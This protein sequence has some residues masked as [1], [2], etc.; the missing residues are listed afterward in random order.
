M[1][2]SG[3]KI[4]APLGDGGMATVYKGLQISLQRPVAIKVLKSKLIDHREIRRRFDRESIIIARLNH[5]NIIHV[6][7]QGVTDC[8]SPY[9]VMEYAKSIGLDAAMRKGSM[10]T[11]RALD[12]FMQIAKALAYAHKNGV[13][14]CDIKPENVLID[15]EGFVRVLD[16]GIAQIYEDAKGGGKDGEGFIMG[17]ANYMA[18]EQQKGLTN[19]TEKSDIYALGVIM[20]LFFTRQLPKGNYPSPRQFDSN[21]PPELDQLIRDCLANNPDDRPASADAIKNCLLRVLQG[22]HL[23]FHQK[24]RAKVDVKK[25]FKLLDVVKE[26]DHG[27]VYLF[28]EQGT[29]TLFVLKKKPIDSPGYDVAEKLAHLEHANIVSIMGTSHNEH[30]FLLVMEYCNGGSLAERLVKPYDLENFYCVAQQVISALLAANECGIIHGNLRPTNILF[31][32]NNCVKVSDFGLDEHY[33]DSDINWYAVPGE[34]KCERADIFSLGV[35]FYQ[36]LAGETPRWKGDRLVK[37]KGFAGLP[38]PLQRMIRKMLA[39]SKENRLETLW[40][41]KAS[42]SRLFGGQKTV[43]RSCT[44]RVAGV[45]ENLAGEILPIDAEGD[46]CVL[47]DSSCAV[48]E[49]RKVP[50]CRLAIAVLGLGVVIAVEVYL[51]MTGRLVEILQAI[52]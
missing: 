8:G 5:P 37:I 48:M 44:T 40:S 52:Y 4:G 35:I 1:E 17:S 24:E 14:H 19:A 23:D 50:R 21:V 36:M 16:F 11:S 43:V 46:L 26:S 45:E 15:F 27:S 34:E 3:Y 41:V 20:Y 2:L 32:D 28:T 47:H 29:N 12:V 22:G 13:I 6:I 9:F 42:L 25:T 39:I 7:D 31:D 18:P 10:T 30:S 49:S 38:E 33:G 51:T